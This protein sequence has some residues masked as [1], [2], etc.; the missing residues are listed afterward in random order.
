MIENF[1]ILCN[2]TSII[3]S[4]F[5]GLHFLFLSQGNKIANLFLGLF[6]IL[7]SISVIHAELFEQL[8]ES[9]WYELVNMLVNSVFITAPILLYYTFALTNTFNENKKKHLW[10]FIPTFIEIGLHLISFTLNSI[11]E[12]RFAPLETLIKFYLLLSFPY[13]IFIFLLILKQVKIHNNNILNLF[14]SI[15]NKQLNWLRLIV[16]VNIGFIIFWLV[17]DTLMFIIGDNLI[18][19]TIALL[20]LYATL[21]NVIWMGFA[22]LRQPIIYEKEIN[23]KTEQI[24]QKS[25]KVV[26]PSIK[27]EELFKQI[28]HNIESQLLFKNSNLSL[29]SLAEA[30]QIRDKELS[31]LINTCYG[32]NFYHFINRFRIQYFKK[33]YSS[34]EHKNLS[35]LGIAEESGFKSKSTFYAAF[36]KIEEMTPKEFE[37]KIS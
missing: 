10:I 5:L 26:E 36:K 35:I 11:T 21:L 32:N 18:S 25:E 9:I 37:L 3:L 4:A 34:A 13:S 31:R 16:I 29:K 17:D 23:E 8:E 2:Y 12:Q 15:E 27:D 24:E 22:S 20:T 28:F 30:L 33:L 1:D 19:E 6:L 14:S 7:T